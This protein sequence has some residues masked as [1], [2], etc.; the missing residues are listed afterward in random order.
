[1]ATIKKNLLCKTVSIEPAHSVV[2][3]NWA[4][5]WQAA[6]QQYDA[7]RSE[8]PMYG[9]ANFSELAALMRRR[10]VVPATQGKNEPP[11]NHERSQTKRIHRPHILQRRARKSSR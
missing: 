4:D 11:S 5:L 9:E 3:R 6:V 7:L 2:G 1:M 8:Y 10:H